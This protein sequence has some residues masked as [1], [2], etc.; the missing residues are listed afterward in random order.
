MIWLVKEKLDTDFRILFENSEQFLHT[1][2]ELLIFSDQLILYLNN[3]ENSNLLS[4]HQYLY[5]CYNVICENQLIFSHWLRLEKQIWQKYLDDMFSNSSS[6]VLNFKIEK[7]SIY[8][9]ELNDF[10]SKN[11]SNFDT[12]KST[13]C[14]ECFILIIKS[15]K[16][17]FYNLPY[18]SKKIRFVSLQIDL[19]KDF[20]LRLCQILRDEENNIFSKAYLGVLTTIDYVIKVLDEWKNSKV[21]KFHNLEEFHK[22]I[23]FYNI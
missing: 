5:N 18:P 17:R 10:W 11:Y 4:D 9:P 6:I 15:I 13:K 8:N 21:R 1:I 12:F 3:K 2:D 14:A 22:K 19:L 20:H 7:S 16:D 23:T